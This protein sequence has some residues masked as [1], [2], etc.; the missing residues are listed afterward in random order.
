MMELSFY[1]NGHKE[2]YKNPLIDE[3][4][5]VDLCKGAIVYSPVF[6][7]LCYDGK[8][9]RFL[10]FVRVYNKERVKFRLDGSLADNADCM[11][12]P[13]K[14]NVMWKH[15]KKCKVNIPRV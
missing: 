9:G 11:L 1:N 14:K 10:Y 6:G 3:I 8:D 2:T 15:G 7:E 12:F 13:S 5:E 4:L